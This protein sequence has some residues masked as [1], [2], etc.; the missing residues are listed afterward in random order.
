MDNYDLIIAYNKMYDLLE[1]EIKGESNFNLEKNYTSKSLVESIYFISIMKIMEIKITDRTP[2]FFETGK[3]YKFKK[4]K[5][6][7]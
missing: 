2:Y 7:N 4:I 1:C 6:L 3:P 5:N